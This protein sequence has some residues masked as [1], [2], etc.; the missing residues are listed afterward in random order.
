[1]LF[2]HGTSVKEVTYNKGTYGKI[3]MINDTDNLEC[4]EALSQHT[5]SVSFEWVHLNTTQQ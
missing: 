2:N 5:S 4:F 1:M 3:T